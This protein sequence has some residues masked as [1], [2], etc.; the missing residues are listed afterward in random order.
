MFIIHHFCLK[1]IYM[2]YKHYVTYVCFVI[3]NNIQMLV[4]ASR[5]YIQI[6]EWIVFGLL[7]LRIHYSMAPPGLDPEEGSQRFIF[8]LVGLLVFW[9]RA[10]TFKP[11]RAACFLFRMYGYVNVC[12]CTYSPPIM[13]SLFLFSFCFQL[14]LRPWFHVLVVAEDLLPS[15]VSQNK[16]PLGQILICVWTIANCACT[17]G[18]THASFPSTSWH[19]TS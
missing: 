8:F 17:E 4:Q 18:H 11:P 16:G 9:F 1:D 10:V 5:T 14:F 13:R 7:L 19:S 15:A 3:L 2:S 6:H 12:V